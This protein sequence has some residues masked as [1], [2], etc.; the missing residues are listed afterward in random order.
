MPNYLTDDAGN[1]LTDDAGNRLTTD[2]TQQQP[3]GQIT[4]RYVYQP[5][6]KFTN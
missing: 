5:N 3:E 6:V 2:E 1:I 4:V